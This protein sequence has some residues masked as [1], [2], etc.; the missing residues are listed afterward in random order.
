MR[1]RK[2]YILSHSIDWFAKIG[3]S[4]AH[5]ASLGGLIPDSADDV[6]NLRQLQALMNLVPDF[7]ENCEIN[8]AFIEQ[9]Y[10]RH[11]RLLNQHNERVQNGI[12]DGLSNEY[13]LIEESSLEEF[14]ADYI[15]LFES[16]ARKGIYSFARYDIDQIENP[17]TALIAKPTEDA[18]KQ[19]NDFLTGILNQTA[20]IHIAGV[21]S[22]RN[23]IEKITTKSTNSHLDFATDLSK[24][25]G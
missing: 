19:L 23:Y 22:F 25:L 13:Q 8:E 21:E 16:Y 7:T 20:D 14:Q 10:Q 15:E 5:C 9:R 24:L 4:W 11:L 2:N 3:N 1:Y 6:T 17:E 12:H 18:A